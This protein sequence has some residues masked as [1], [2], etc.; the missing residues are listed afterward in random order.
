MNGKCILRAVTGEPV[1][2]VTDEAVTIVTIVTVVNL[3][4]ITMD[5]A[6]DSRN[7]E[8]SPPDLGSFSTIERQSR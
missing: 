6:S 7:F 2:V 1:T 5:L 3:P 8:G 4:G